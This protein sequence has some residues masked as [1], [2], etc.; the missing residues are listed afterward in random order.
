MLAYWIS[1]VIMFYRFVTGYTFLFTVLLAGL[2]SGCA[3]KQVKYIAVIATA[4]ETAEAMQKWARSCAMCHV[5]GE[6]GAP[7]VGNSTDWQARIAKG[8]TALLSHT[9]QGFKRMPPLGYC[10]DCSNT[11]FAI[12]IEFMSGVVEQ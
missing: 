8:Q 10:M 7:T 2:L 11:D 4:D 12:L 5:N 3:D 1:G 6:G 9:L